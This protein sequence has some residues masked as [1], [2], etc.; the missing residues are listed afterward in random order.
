MAVA[1]FLRFCTKGLKSI[2][3]ESKK[4]RSH[5]KDPGVTLLNM[6]PC[7]AKL[8]REYLCASS[9]YVPVKVHQNK[10]GLHH[11]IDIPDS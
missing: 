1:M 6:D 7:R 10:N 5:K 9:L 11:K 8:A 4:I 2:V 3:V